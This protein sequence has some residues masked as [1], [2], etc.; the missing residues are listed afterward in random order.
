M[1]YRCISV[2]CAIMLHV[3]N[4][5][6]EELELRMGMIGR[7]AC[8]NDVSKIVLYVRA[9]AKQLSFNTA[10]HFFKLIEA[11]FSFNATYSSSGIIQASGD[12]P[13]ISQ[14]VI[15]NLIGT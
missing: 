4:R 10:A 13:N 12:T 9:A 2:V 7:D 15:L 5:I 3:T 8:K 1:R 14:S 6:K 11:K